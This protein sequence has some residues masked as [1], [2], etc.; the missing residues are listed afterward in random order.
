MVLVW[1]FGEHSHLFLLLL[2]AFFTCVKGRNE[3]ST[4]PVPAC[5]TG[6]FVHLRGFFYGVKTH[7]E[8]LTFNLRQSI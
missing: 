6:S 4:E 8:K 5:F 7:A 2:T 1:K 3:T